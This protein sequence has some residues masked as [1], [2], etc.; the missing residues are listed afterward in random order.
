MF[1]GAHPWKPMPWSSWDTVLMLMPGEV[2]N[3]AVID[4]SERCWGL[5]TFS[6]PA[7][8]T[9]HLL[10][11]SFSTFLSFLNAFAT[12]W[13]HTAT[14]VFA[15]SCYSGGFCIFNLAQ[16]FTL[17]ALP[18]TAFPGIYVYS[19]YWTEDVSFWRGR[20]H[21]YVLNLDSW[22]TGLGPPE[23]KG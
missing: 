1:R 13:T 9:L 11:L 15:G 14:A 19:R 17:D 10:L 4:P 5:C 16:I 12:L 3:C 21:V 22:L 8:L 18:D 6:N 20:L 2:W 7:L 23:F